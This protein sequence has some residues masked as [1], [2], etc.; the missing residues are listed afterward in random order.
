LVSKTVGLRHGRA[1]SRDES[2]PRSILLGGRDKSKAEGLA[3]SKYRPRRRLEANPICYRRQ[4]FARRDKPSDYR[5]RAKENSF[6]FAHVVPG[7]NPY[8]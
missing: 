6:V 3:G 1:D 8:A 5:R 7:R 2:T 4:L